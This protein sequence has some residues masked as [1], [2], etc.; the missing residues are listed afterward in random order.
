M[1]RPVSSQLKEALRLATERFAGALPG[2]PGEEYLQGRRIGPRAAER[3]RLG[4]VSLDDPP[5]GWERYAGRLAIP[6]LN[7]KG[8]PVWL[9]F[10]A[11]PE[12]RP[13]HKGEIDKYA[14]EPGGGTRLYNT[15]ALSASGDTLCLVEGE[16]DAITLTALGLPAVGIPGAKS[17]KEWFPKALEGWPRTVMFYDDDEPGRN[18]VKLVKKGIPDIIPLPA[19]GGHHDVGEAYEAGLG[20]AIVAAAHGTESE[21]DHAHEHG[22]GSPERDEPNL[23]GISNPDGRIPY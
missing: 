17:W 4:Y 18:L 6:Y 21:Q 12:T 10:R 2:S 11:T 8:D 22:N 23:D 13:N 19:P 5:E 3:L 20:E 14:Q 16:F 1:L 15:I 9:K 7:V